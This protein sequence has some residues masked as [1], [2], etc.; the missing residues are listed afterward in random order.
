MSDIGLGRGRARRRAPSDASQA[1]PGSREASQFPSEIY[2]HDVEQVTSQIK[3]VDIGQVCASGEPPIINFMPL[4]ESNDK[5][6]SSG[7]RFDVVSNLFK[8]NAM[9]TGGIYLYHVDF[10]PAVANKNLRRVM[11]AEHTKVIGDVY[12][13]DGML[14]FLPVQLSEPITELK[15][16]RSTDNQE[17]C[18]RIKFTTEV[19]PQSSTCLQ[20][21]N[22]TFKK[23]L[24]LVDLKQIGRNYFSPSQAAEIPQHKLAVWPGFVTSI[25]QFETSTMLMADLCHKIL[26]TSSVLDIMYEM[27]NK[28]RGN[29]Q[30]FHEACSK[31]IIGQIVLT[32]Y[33]N[34]TYKID[35]IDWNGSPLSPF[36]RSDGTE[37]TYR[38]YFLA[39]HGLK[40]H[41]LDQPL[42]LSNPKQK[43][44]RQGQ[45]GPLVFLPEL[46]HLTGI[47][48]EV[49]TDYSVM[50]DIA[51]HT[52]IEPATRVRTLEGFIGKL[53][54]NDAARKHLNNWHLEFARNLLSTTARQVK[55]EA[56]KQHDCTL[57]YNPMTAD[58]SREM[59][60][61]KFLA[62]ENMCRWIVVVTEKDRRLAEN[63][64]DT[65]YN[66]FPQ[67]G[68]EVSPCTP[69]VLNNDN[70]ETYINGL[71]EYVRDDTQIVICI[72]GTNRNDRYSAIKHF[73]CI[74]KPVPSQIVLART[75]SKSN[76]L[77]SVATKIAIQLSSKMG[78]EIWAV[79]VP[80]KDL[81]VIGID[82]YHDS[83]K[84]G[85]SVGAFVASFNKNLTRYYSRCVLQANQQELMHSL[86]CF[87]RDALKHY[88]RVNG[89]LPATI[90]VY[91]DG[92]GDGQLETVHSFEVTQLRECIKSMEADYEP[93][94]TFIVVKKRINSRFFERSER[95]I[96]NPPP[97]TVIDTEAT[98]PEWYDFFLV[99]QSVRQGTVAP[100]H[101]NIIYDSSNLIAEHQQRLAY[102]LTHLY[103]NWPGTIRVPAPCQY[104]HKL[105]FLVG[106][107]LHREAANK[108]YDKFYYL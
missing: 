40:V 41:D 23:V 37:M 18:I 101:Y 28:H 75:L 47:A 73:L 15:S 31:K 59:K 46:C 32:R 9:P 95:G 10:M 35:E 91:R 107:S 12:E 102:K 97:G 104:A 14:L 92:V 84:K 64:V 25:L 3:N 21:L 22:I 62:A 87:L 77:I 61:R 82:C 51:V 13:F 106:Q 103:Y 5:K 85:Q 94:F 60:N 83:S 26:H 70:T 45:T 43:D 63:L 98:R 78:A 80:V 89:R 24:G 108:L 49:R 65:L 11:I 79:D 38:D 81:M 30:N 58:W 27:Y 34:K 48:D 66:I 33:N 2:G 4:M 90:V 88:K 6:G 96:T 8:V 39:E 76:M 105:A 52:R 1:S 29:T 36:T 44:V 72:L 93:G 19:D 71:R 17:I 53:H 74:E 68:V 20:L 7:R 99:S 42:L 50:K 67:M 55:A 16:I 57:R 100:T 54:T 56:I 86:N 69:V